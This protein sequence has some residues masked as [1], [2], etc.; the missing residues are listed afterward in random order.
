MSP[1]TDAW[2]TPL[3]T[4]KENEVNTIHLHTDVVLLSNQQIDHFLLYY[5]NFDIIWLQ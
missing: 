4:W 2:G 1:K 3:E 5:M